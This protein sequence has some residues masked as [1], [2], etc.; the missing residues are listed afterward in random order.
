ML[1]TQRPSPDYWAWDTQGHPSHQ[2]WGLSGSSL[3]PSHSSVPASSSYEAV[4]GPTGAFQNLRVKEDFKDPGSELMP[5]SSRQE[6]GQR[7][8][9][10]VNIFSGRTSCLGALYREMECVL[11]NSVIGPDSCCFWPSHLQPKHSQ[12][13]FQKQKRTCHVSNEEAEKCT[14]FLCPGLPEP[15]RLPDLAGTWAWGDDRGQT[16]PGLRPPPN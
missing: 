3:N 2:T 13:L 1:N 9:H 6:S 8:L 5:E 10:C 15:K 14:P 7:P 4:P 16:R 11:C 12:F